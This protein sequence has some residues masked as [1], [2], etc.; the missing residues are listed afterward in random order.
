MQRDITYQPTII[1][2]YITLSHL[3][4]VQNIKKTTYSN[5]IK[6]QIY[7]IQKKKNSN[8]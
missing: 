6:T 1:V 7:I 3:F 5:N 8:I 2:M 4:R